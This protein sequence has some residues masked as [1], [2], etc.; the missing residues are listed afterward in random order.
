MY[1]LNTDKLR[2]VL[3]RMEEALAALDRLRE[4]DAEAFCEDPLL[5][6]ALERGI[7]VCLECVADAGNTL[8][9]GFLMRDPGSYADIVDILEGEEV[10]P[11][12][13]AAA[14]RELVSW[15]KALVTDM[16]APPRRDRLHAFVRTHFEALKRFPAHVRAYVHRELGAF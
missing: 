10:V 14:Y 13:D 4:R 8:I 1:E 2:A 6:L 7:H 12:E 3:A 9:D 5:A 11:A 16:A 15:R